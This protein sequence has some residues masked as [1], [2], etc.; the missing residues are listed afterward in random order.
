[1]TSYVRICRRCNAEEP[2][3]EMTCSQC[4]EFLGAEA[5]VPKS[6]PNQ[7]EYE[8]KVP[9][10]LSQQK[11]ETDQASRI[12]DAVF[13]LEVKQ[14]GEV[15]TIH[16]GD[17]IGQQHERSQAQ[18]QLSGAIPG[19]ECLHRYHCKMICNSGQL[20]EMTWWILALD[21]TRYGSPFTNPTQLNQTTLTP[22][23]RTRLYDGDQLKLSGLCLKVCLL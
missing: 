9:T 18:V 13:Y 8:E 1:M 3:Y 12:S 14:T 23:E 16:S 7:P 17:I 19:C 10:E 4:D 15:L 5:A 6:D 2:E 22:G 20:S 11:T 21:Q